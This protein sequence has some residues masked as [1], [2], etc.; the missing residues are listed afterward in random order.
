[1]MILATNPMTLKLFNGNS[2]SQSS[3]WWEG[4]AK[5]ENDRKIRT[6]SILKTTAERKKIHQNVNY[7]SSFF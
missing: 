2:H 3:V 5:G 1:M 6:T 4:R 7:Y